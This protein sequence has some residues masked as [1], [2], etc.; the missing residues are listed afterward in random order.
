M[1]RFVLTFLFYVIVLNYKCN[2]VMKKCCFVQINTFLLV[3]SVDAAV[4]RCEGR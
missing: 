2:W 3:L 4:I 1:S